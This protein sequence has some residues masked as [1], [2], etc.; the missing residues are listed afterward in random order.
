AFYCPTVFLWF[1]DRWGLPSFPGFQCPRCKS[2]ELCSNG[3]YWRRVIGLDCSYYIVGEEKQCKSCKNEVGKTTS[4]RTWMDSAVSL[5]PPLLQNIF[6]ILPIHP[7]S[8]FVFDRSVLEEMMT[9]VPQGFSAGRYCRF[10]SERHHLRHVKA[11]TMYYYNF[12]RMRKKVEY[13]DTAEVELF[14]SFGDVNGYNGVV[15]G[16]AAIK[17]MFY[18]EGLLDETLQDFI[19]RSLQL[20]DATVMKGDATFKFAKL[21]QVSGVKNGKRQK[22]FSCTFTLFNGYQQCVGIWHLTGESQDELR[23]VLTKVAE[24][25][26]S[27][28]F[29]GPLLFYTDR[30]C[31]ERD[32]LCSIFQSLA[33][34]VPIQ[35]VGSPAEPS[36]GHHVPQQPV[37]YLSTEDCDG[38]TFNYV[39]DQSVASA[40]CSAIMQSNSGINLVGFD[41]EWTVP[42]LCRANRPLDGMVATIQIA[43]P[44]TARAYPGASFIFHLAQMKGIPS[45]LQQLLASASIK[46][47][48]VGI[49]GDRT[50]LLKERPKLQ[51]NNLED[52]GQLAKALHLRN[53]AQPMTYSL[54]NLCARLFNKKL[55][56]SYQCSNWD[57]VLEKP[58]QKY[59]ALDAWASLNCY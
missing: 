22:P 39:A 5:L 26:L 34:S 17:R 23:P 10:L 28:G 40:I 43:I 55:D 24:R 51:F 49:K 14:S 31:Q 13:I 8:K 6:P 57:R 2:H 35:T 16:P 3:Y 42:Y 9:L 38:F 25:F 33:P 7:R 19:R 30:C 36:G 48:G 37:P 53:G 52:V 32:F 45:Q 41:M 58:Q 27:Q 1:P 29:I 59:A 21:I 11:E 44:Q 12:L 47:V 56:K 54:S 15:P 4:F 20:V 50:R 46:K 18:K